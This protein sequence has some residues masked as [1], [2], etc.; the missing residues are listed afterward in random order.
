MIS[1][2]K[3]SILTD[4][5]AGAGFLAEHGLSYFVETNET[6]FLFDFGSTDVFL[7]NAEKIKTDLSKVKT[8]VLSHGHWDH[9]NGLVHLKNKKLITHPNSFI[10]RFRKSN[11]EFLGLNL[12]E[13][14]IAKKHK[15]T[16]TSSHF[17]ISDNIVFLGEIERT[18]DFEKWSSPYIDVFGNDDFVIDDTA[19]AI[20]K[21]NELNIVTGCSHSGICNIIEHAKKV[22][23]IKKVNAVIGG[24][25]LKKSD[26]RTSKT[27]QYFKDN[28][29]KKILPSHCT[30]LPALAEF[31]KE[32]KINQ[33]KTGMVITL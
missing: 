17:N 10:Q 8:I 26:E 33:I 15:I 19:V 27:I 5:Y 21:S 11:N 22:T 9:G 30:Q 3:I 29:I 31:Y 18:L 1:S 13:E 12:S 25:H 16:K 23:G 6:N 24:F 7:K 32:F 20:I 28:N 4:N 14:Q 2:I